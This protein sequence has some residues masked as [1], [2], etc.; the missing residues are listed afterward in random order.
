MNTS[1]ED[2]KPSDNME[3]LKQQAAGCGPGCACHATGTPGKTRWVIGAIVLAAAGVMVVRAM[4]KSDTASTRSSA[5]AFAPLAAMP[6]PVGESVP[7]TNSSTAVPTTEKSVETIGTLSELNTVAAN[8]DAVFVFLPGNEFASSNPP[9]TPMNGAARAIE[10]NA[11]KKCG[12][13][14]LKAGSRD[15]DQLAVQVGVP[16]VL[17]MVKGRGMS[18]IS[19]DITEAKL[20]QGFVAAS[21]AGGC[22]PSAGAGCCPK[23]KK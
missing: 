13:F 21:S 1:N 19:G 23:P 14:T 11:G 17:A 7:A 18:A 5:P 6:T 20:V 8:T 3:L 9:L 4:I 2:Q 12:L 16:A 22:G 15:Y 10:S